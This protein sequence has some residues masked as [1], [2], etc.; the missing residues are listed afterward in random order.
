[1]TALNGF[2]ASAIVEAGVT[3]EVRCQEGSNGRIVAVYLG[4]YGSRIRLQGDPGDVLACVDRL[5]T[6]AIEAVAAAWPGGTHH[7]EEVPA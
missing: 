7:V 5:R 6:A 3:V 4:E 1:V 2:E